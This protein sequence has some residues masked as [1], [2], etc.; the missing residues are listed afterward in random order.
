MTSTGVSGPETSAPTQ[1]WPMT[2]SPTLSMETSTSRRLSAVAVEGI[3]PLI[4]AMA[5]PAVANSGVITPR[6]RPRSTTATTT[7]KTVRGLSLNQ[8]LMEVKA[9]ESDRRRRLILAEDGPQ[10]RANLPERCLGT[11]GIQDARHQRRIR[12]RCLLDRGEHDVDGASITPGSVRREP[13]SLL[14]HGA[15]V[16]PEEQRSSTLLGLG[17][18]VDAD[19]DLISDRYRALG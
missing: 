7:R 14:G 1:S 16:G 2:G 15:F 12:R 4:S 17:V 9:R 13:C 3:T 10:R 8:R 5:G 11:D 18:A 19:N 6:N